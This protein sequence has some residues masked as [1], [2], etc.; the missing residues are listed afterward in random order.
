MSEEHWRPSEL[1]NRIY[2]QPL[3]KLDHLKRGR[4]RAALRAP[5]AVF[6]VCSLLITSPESNVG[7]TYCS[8]KCAHLFCHRG[9]EEPVEGNS[10]LTGELVCCCL[11]ILTL[12]LLVFTTDL[13]LYSLSHFMSA[14][15][16]FCVL[17]SPRSSF[18]KQAVNESEHTVHKSQNYCIHRIESYFLRLHHWFVEETNWSEIKGQQ[19]LEVVTHWQAAWDAGW[20]QC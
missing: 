14:V 12:T 13:C 5:N 15:K 7:I 18:Q 16:W 10:C 11:F 9:D 6:N 8:S 20:A 19:N 3:F 1:Q 17:F 2:Q 4:L